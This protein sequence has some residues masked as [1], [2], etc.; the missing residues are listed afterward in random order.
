MSGPLAEDGLPPIGHVLRRHGIVQRTRHGQHFI[1][2]LNFTRRIAREA[3]DLKDSDVLE[4]GAGPGGLTRALLLEGARKVIAVERDHRCL[5]ALEEVASHWPGRLDIISG[6]ALKLDIP[7]QLTGRGRLRI[8]SNLPYQIAA[9][10]LVRWVSQA[11]WPPWWSDAT[12]MVQREM[13]DRIVASPSTRSYGRLSVLLQWRTEVRVVMS[14]PPEVF[15]PPPK[16]HSSLLRL[17][18]MPNPE[19]G[20][21]VS[22]LERV[23][24]A[25]FGNRRKMLRNSL[26]TLSTD[27]LAMLN[28][29]GILAHLRAQDLSVSDYC[30]L[31]RACSSCLCFKN[32]Y[33]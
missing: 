15:M 21:A 20:F 13:A 18:P 2:D 26:T 24:A 7:K 29:V 33:I 3:G 1:H 4:V 30:A 28:T 5:P 19:G 16:V 12:V 11:E 22:D 17:D 25:A 9:P 23:T 27:V 14:V 8:V 31:A 6:D 10:L 32:D